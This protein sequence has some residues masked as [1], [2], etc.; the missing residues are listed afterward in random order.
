MSTSESTVIMGVGIIRVSTAYY[1]SKSIPGHSIYLVDSSPEL[2]ASALGKAG[3]FL[4]ADWFDSVFAR[5]GLL[6]FRL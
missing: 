5:L 3:G 4:T 6:P 2:F 1:L